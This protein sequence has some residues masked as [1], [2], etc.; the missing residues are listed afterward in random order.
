TKL[1][2]LCV[3]CLV[4]IMLVNLAATARFN[5]QKRKASEAG[6]MDHGDAIGGDHPGGFLHPDL[7][8]EWIGEFPHSKIITDSFGFRTARKIEAQK[9]ANT[10]RIL[11]VG[12]SFVVGLRT[13]QE[14]TIGRN[15]EKELSARL[16]GQNVEVLIAGEDNPYAYLDY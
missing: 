5:Y 3:G 2:L 12:D 15:L 4:G 10:I 7:N 1:K 16:A 6:L 8:R 13:D 14:Q 11:F 9:P